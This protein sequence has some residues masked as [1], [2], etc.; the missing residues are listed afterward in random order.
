MLGV[1]EGVAVS[2]DVRDARVEALMTA[3][4]ERTTLAEMHPVVLT[5]AELLRDGVPLWLTLTDAL[6]DTLVEYAFVADI[7]RDT[8]SLDDAFAEMLGVVLVEMLAVPVPQAL[9]RV[10]TE[11]EPVVESEGRVEADV[12]AL[13]LGV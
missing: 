6:V 3:L 10:E 9:E 2:V 4:W 12:C 7:L 1:G 13:L 11:G 8:E 5:D